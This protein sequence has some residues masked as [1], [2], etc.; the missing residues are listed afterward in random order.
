M[1]LFGIVFFTIN[2]KSL[3]SLTLSCT[4]KGLLILI[5]PFDALI[6]KMA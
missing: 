5:P 6:L 2:E 4:E 1:V 3:L